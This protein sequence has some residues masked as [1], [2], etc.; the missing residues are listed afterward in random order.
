[1]P[2]PK[3]NITDDERKQ[4]ALAATQRSQARMRIAATKW[5]NLPLVITSLNDP[6]LSKEDCL[7]ILYKYI[8]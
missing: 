2:R 7:N 3:L 6:L 5:K 8:S 4:R 1:M